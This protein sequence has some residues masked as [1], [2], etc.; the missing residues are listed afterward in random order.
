MNIANAMKNNNTRATVFN[1][2]E[3]YAG[4]RFLGATVAF[5]IE[6]D[7][8]YEITFLDDTSIKMGKR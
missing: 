5:Y 3:N 1:A 7:K 8:W 4:G 2:L 6:N